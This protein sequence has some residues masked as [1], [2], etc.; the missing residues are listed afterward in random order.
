MHKSVLGVL[1]ALFGALG[2]V[3]VAQ[4]F[5]TR[6]DPYKSYKVAQFETAVPAAGGHGRSCYRPGAFRLWVQAP[7][8]GAPPGYFLSAVLPSLH[9]PGMIQ[10]IELEGGLALDW[11]NHESANVNCGRYGC[12]ND[13]AITY[14]IPA[15]TMSALRSRDSTSLR[16]STSEGADCDATVNITAEQ[17][18]T[19]E[20][21]AAARLKSGEY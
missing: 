19:L 16:I 7:N 6:A 17:V 10:A 9:T 14:S 3:A 4:E 2:P 5:S 12:R 18:R 15:A 13:A 8:D 11:P 1:V 21:W 20:G